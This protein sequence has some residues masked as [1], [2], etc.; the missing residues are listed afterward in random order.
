MN[1]TCVHDMMSAGFTDLYCGIVQRDN[2][3]EEEHGNWAQRALNIQQTTSAIID[4]LSYIAVKWP[5][6]E[7]HVHMFRTLAGRVDDSM[8]VGAAERELR[9]HYI[10]D[11]LG[12]VVAGDSHRNSGVD[13]P[14]DV[15]DAAMAAFLDQP[16]DLGNIDWGTVDWEAMELLN[17]E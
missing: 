13:H 1:W 9:A 6:V 12:A 15:W 2:A 7:T 3:Q 17:D 10:D 4:I 11:A 5:L 8:R 16:L 14:A